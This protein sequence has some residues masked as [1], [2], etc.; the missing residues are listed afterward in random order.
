MKRPW[1]PALSVVLAAVACV[2]V[3]VGAERPPAAKKA[4]PVKVLQSWNGKL[5][6]AALRKSVPADGVVLDQEVWAGLWKAWRGQENL[7]AVDFQKQMVLVFTADGPNSVGCNPT[8]DGQGHIQAQAM[9]TLI[10]GPGF[11]YL[12]LCVS[13]EGM[14]SVN[15]KP[16]P[17][18]KAPPKRPRGK[19]QGAPG[20]V[21][22]GAPGSPPQAVP[23]SSPPGGPGA[24]EGAVGGEAQ[25]PP[26][27]QLD[28]LVPK[29]AVFEGSS[30]KTPR[31]LK[32][33][34]D[35]AEWFDDDELA[36]LAK[37]VDFGKQVV[38]LFAWRGS[39]QDRLDAAVAES[40]PEQVFFSLT[41]GRTRDLRQHVR[42]FALR[43]NVQWRVK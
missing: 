25:T 37:Q 24:V 36:K 3:A 17:G 10:G 23:G 32:S 2:V 8:R 18:G 29:P 20:A 14:Q 12:M 35:A 31:A 27:V 16:L 34:K 42:I 4:Q 28:R 30:W 9:S 33:A 19:P 7:P 1:F 39:G 43:S 5:A 6:D 22:G 11:G 40:Y 13:R 21:P 15:G 41:P 26:I 38:L